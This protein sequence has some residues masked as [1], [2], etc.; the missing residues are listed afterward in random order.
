VKRWVKVLLVLLVACI[1]LLV[2]NA[3]TL[4]SKTEDAEVNVEGAELIDTSSGTL[5]VLDEGNPEGSPVVLIHGATES[6]HWFEELAPLLAANHRVI[7]ID[8]LGHGGSDKPG[9]GYA[10][11]DQAS[12]V[13]EALAKLEVTDATVLGNS[14]GGSVATGLAEESPDLVAGIVIVDQAPNDSYSELPVTVELMYWPIVG[15]ALSRASDVVP[16][17]V[18]LDAYEDAFAPG[19]NIASGFEDPDQP[20]DDLREMTYTAFD[21]INSA[22]AE[23]RDARTLD[24]RLSAIEVPL[25]VIFGAEDQIYDA[26]EAIQPYEDVTG[27]RTELLDGVGHSP[28]VEVPEKVAALLE[29]FIARNEATARAERRATARREAQRRAARKAARAKAR[30]NRKAQRAA[31]EKAAKGQKGGKEGGQAQGSAEQGG[32]QPAEGN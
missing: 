12:A 4:T 7:R 6:M 2:L 16:D 9:A 3:I 21:D 8:L 31:Q 24:D 15:P 23:Y 26:E 1:A 20:V 22:D 5:Q 10:I 30:A 25:M 28:N 29:G 19:F 11:A 14:L 13:A 18:V 32:N 17:S 27:A